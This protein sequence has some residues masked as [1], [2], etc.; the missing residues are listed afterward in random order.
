[1]NK[2]EFDALSASDRAIAE[3]AYRDGY[4][5]AVDVV[6]SCVQRLG[7]SHVD[8]IFIYNRDTIVSMLKAGLK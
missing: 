8:Q 7:D 3:K 6:Q 1:M 2:T 5:A 4:A